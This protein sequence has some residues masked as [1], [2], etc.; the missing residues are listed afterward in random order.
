MKA[1]VVKPANKKNSKQATTGVAAARADYPSTN[2]SSP[3]AAATKRRHRRVVE[4]VDEEEE[5]YTG[6]VTGRHANGYAQDNFVVGDDWEETDKDEDG[7]EPVLAAPKL[8]P[9]KRR[10]PGP[11]ITTDPRRASLS[12]LQLM[13]LDAF[14]EQAKE[15]AKSIMVTKNLHNQPFSDTILREIGIRLPTTDGELLE[16]KGI[17]PAMV[18]LY[19]KSFLIMARRAKDIFNDQE[20][21]VD[22]PQDPNHRVIEISDDESETA[23][24]DYGSS[25]LEGEEGEL[26]D[27][28]SA[29]FV[30]DSPYHPPADVREFNQL[31][32]HT[33][34]PLPAKTASMSASKPAGYA[35]KKSGWS[36]KGRTVSRASYPPKRRSY[37]GAKKG[38]SKK[39]GGNGRAGGGGGAR[40]GAG[41]GGGGFGGIGMMPTG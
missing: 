39:T 6:G 26:L 13:V 1:K 30:P 23:E 29:Y 35:N 34:G 15:K 31:L 17:N 38:H 3:V 24:S 12:E 14:M 21:D 27:Q 11:P 25:L 8:E 22:V 37:G 28:R 18:R 5:E 10:N 41:G 40:R 20:G 9:I 36:N 19:G 7:F 4:D 2:L 16:I 32:S 33:A